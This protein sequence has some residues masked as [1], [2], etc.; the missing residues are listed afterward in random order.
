M[1]DQAS[2][3]TIEAARKLIRTVNDA[4]ATMRIVTD[5]SDVII[6]QAVAPDGISGTLSLDPQKKVFP[7]TEDAF[8]E[9]DF[10]RAHD[11]D[12]IKNRLIA[13]WPEFAT[14]KQA[15][16]D[17]LWKKSGGQS[18]GKLTFG[19]CTKMS[20]LALYYSGET[21]TIWIAA[22]HVRDHEFTQ[23]QLEA[24]IYHELSH[25]SWEVDEKTGEMKWMV[26]ATTPRSSLTRSRAMARGNKISASCGKATSSWPWQQASSWAVEAP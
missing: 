12:E 9:T 26:T 20:G 25:C 21:F 2:S 19:K 23:L 8:E 3:E 16:I 13:S 24:L 15:N 14:L 7:P 10:I 6:G 4:G 22:D 18:G 11:L 1:V 5:S 17:I